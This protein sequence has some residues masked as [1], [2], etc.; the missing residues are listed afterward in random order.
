VRAV[1]PRREGRLAKATLKQ[2]PGEVGAYKCLL[3]CQVQKGT[4]KT[5]L[6]CS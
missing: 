2:R 5:K 1:A 6:V 4:K 3:K